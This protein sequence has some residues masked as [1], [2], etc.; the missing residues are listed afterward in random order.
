MEQQHPCSHGR[1]GKQ[2][3]G[4]HRACGF[5]QTGTLPRAGYKFGR[6]LDVVFMSRDLLP[7]TPKPQGDG[8]LA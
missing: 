4:V 6:W 3:I 8:W 1:F 5:E 7:P 2:S